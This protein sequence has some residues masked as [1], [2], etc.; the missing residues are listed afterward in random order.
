MKVTA[1]FGSPRKNGNS[2]AIAETF[3]RE[4][5]KD[6]GKIDRYHLNTMK[7][8][9]CQGCGA[10]K[11][12]SEV[13]IV[14]DNLTAVLDGIMKADVVLLATPIYFHEIS[15]QAK[16]FIDRT[17]SYFKPNFFTLK[18]PSRIPP[19]KDFVFI[20]SQGAPDM[21][22]KGI[23]DRYETIFKSMGFNTV[24]VLRGCE[25]ASI[26]DAEKNTEI[27][28]KAKNTAVEILKGKA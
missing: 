9:G 16:A 26:G 6:G 24:H 13:C 10:C 19:E 23:I 25:M 3:L 15:S 12:E 5:E 20:T 4:M 1:I 18:N 11:G 17:Y 27:M 8:K 7:F 14:K 21:M 22:F 2:A 28:E